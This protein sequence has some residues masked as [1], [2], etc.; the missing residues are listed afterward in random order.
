MSVTKVADPATAYPTAT[1]FVA[2]LRAAADFFEKHPDLAPT[3]GKT[4][5]DYFAHS[6]DE[7]AQIARRIGYAEKGEADVWFY[8]RKDFGGNVVLD[9]NVA[10][11]QVCRRVVTGTVEHPEEAREA[12]T[13]EIVEWVCDEPVLG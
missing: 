8:L 2:G 13:E 12:W 1:E 10:R 4:R 9:V 5:F 7:L 6:K 3:Y 11:E